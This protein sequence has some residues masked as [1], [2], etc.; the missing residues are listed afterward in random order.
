MGSVS[1]S[2]PQRVGGGK[3]LEFGCVGSASDKARLAGTILRWRGS[4]PKLGNPAVPCTSLGGE[5]AETVPAGRWGRGGRLP[6]CPGTTSAD[7]T[8]QEGGGAIL[9]AHTRWPCMASHS[10][11]HAPTAF[12][13]F[14]LLTPQ[15]WTGQWTGPQQCG[16]SHICLLN[17]CPKGGRGTYPTQVDDSAGIC[18]F[19]AD[20]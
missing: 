17:A 10:N 20:L 5:S 8:R 18:S 1:H 19:A 2:V 13:P 14:T 4:L 6:W 9:S 12:I 7:R 3:T 16:S 11:P 15:L